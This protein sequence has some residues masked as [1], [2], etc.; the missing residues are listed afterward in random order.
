MS[1]D[2][3]KDEMILPYK[4]YLL[5]IAISISISAILLYW[6]FTHLQLLYY[7]R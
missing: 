3:L 4:I 7:I 6:I 2:E 1:N 5:I